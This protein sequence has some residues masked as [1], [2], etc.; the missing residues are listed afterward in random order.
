VVFADTYYFFA[1]LS[2]KDEGHAM[3]VT[4]SQS[5]QGRLITSEWIL[6]ELGDGLASSRQRHLFGPLRRA[7]IADPNYQILTWDETL[8]TKG[9]QLYEARPDKDWSLTNCIS[10]VIMQQ[11]GIQEALTGDRHFEQA[12]FIAVF[13]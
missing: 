11:H 5:Y 1:M 3:T 8:Y 10:F 4:W 6:L 13:K 12:G 9:L 2:D 7:L